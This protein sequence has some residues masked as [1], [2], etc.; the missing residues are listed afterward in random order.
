MVA[1]RHKQAT[2]WV[3]AVSLVRHINPETGLPIKD[4]SF[5]G[6]DANF[7]V[8]PE[9]ERVAYHSFYV[10]ELKLKTLLPMD[11]ETA[12]LAGVSFQI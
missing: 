3:K 12:Q 1:P 10:N 4:M 5:V 9:G 7:D 6:R 2:L 11:L 8:I